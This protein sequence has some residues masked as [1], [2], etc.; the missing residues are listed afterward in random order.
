[1]PIEHQYVVR[2]VT[3]L[4]EGMIEIEWTD[5]AEHDDKGG[6]FMRTQI[7]AEGQETDQQVGYWAAELRQDADEMLYAWLKVRRG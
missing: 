5:V 3:F 1:M 6:T 4:D 2:S 7:T